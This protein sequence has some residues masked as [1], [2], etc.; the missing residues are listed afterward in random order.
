MLDD[1]CYKIVTM[2]GTLINLTDQYEVH[3]S[4]MVVTTLNLIFLVIK[5]FSTTVPDII[6]F[7]KRN[8]LLKLL[9]ATHGIN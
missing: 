3:R 5:C 9:V 4:Y 1:Q 7:Q 2:K 6:T 8:L